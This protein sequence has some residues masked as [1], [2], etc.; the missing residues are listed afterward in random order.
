MAQ[1]E[2]SK[3][4]RIVRKN[5]NTVSFFTAVWYNIDIKERLEEVVA[6]KIIITTKNFNASDALKET[7]EKKLGKLGKYF[8]DEINANVKLSSEGSRDKIE[9]TI[10]NTGTIFRAEE[11]GNDIYDSIDRIVDKLSN[12]MSRFKTKLQRKHKDNKDVF[13]AELPEID[14]TEKEI[15]IVRTKKFQLEPM[16]AEEAIM[17]MELLGHNFFVFLDMET[18]SVNVVYRRKNNSYGLL[19][20][21]Y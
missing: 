6:M 19:E 11:A 17:Q 15:D 3:V 14:E 16:N 9:A 10:S 12:Q 4:L 20:T 21:T 18:D 1:Y 5:K 8:S 13:F 7:I 2:I